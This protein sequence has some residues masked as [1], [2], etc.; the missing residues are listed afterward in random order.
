MTFIGTPCGAERVTLAQANIPSDHAFIHQGIAYTVS[1]KLDILAAGVGGLQITVPQGSYVHFKPA[2]FS[3]TGGPVIISLLEDYTFVGGSAIPS[4]NRKR[5][6]TNAAT[7]TV[8]G[9]TAI[10][11]VAGSAPLNLETLILSGNTTA[12][13]LGSAVTQ[14]KEWVLK[15]GDYLIGITNSTSPGA[16]VSVAYDLFWYEEGGE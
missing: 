8:K 10:T 15:P 12:G 1:N 4:V 7:V 3:C 6:S 13:R 9:A 2:A 14:D 5:S 16:T 11:P